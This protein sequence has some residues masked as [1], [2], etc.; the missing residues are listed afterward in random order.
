MKSGRLVKNIF[1]DTIVYGFTRYLAVFA[2]VFLT[3]I[4]TRIL[5]KEDFGTMDIF[6]TWNALFIAILPL[7]LF[8]ALLRFFPDVKDDLTERKKLFGATLTSIFV[9]CMLYVGFIL[10]FKEKFYSIF[11]E[12]ESFNIVFYLSAYIVVNAVLHAYFLQVLQIRF[13]KYKYMTI[14]LINFA[15][16][17]SLGFYL[18]Y[19]L[20]QGIAG[21]FRASAIAF[22]ASNLVGAIFVGRDLHF[23]FDLSKIRMLLSYSI[24]FV[25][26]FFLLQLSQ[27]VDRFLLSEYLNL[28][29]VGIYSVAIRVG[30]ILQIAIS[31]FGTA[32][33]PYAMTIKNE[34]NNKQIYKGMLDIFVMVFV[35][36]IGGMILFRKEI[37]LL[38]APAYMD[39]YNTIFWVLLSNFVMG[40]IYVLSLGIQIVR[41]SKFLSIAAII[42][43]SANFFVSLILVKVVG[44]EGVAIGT[45]VGAMIWIGIQHYFSQKYYK[46][47][48]NY[49]KNLATIALL[50]VPLL[51]SIWLDQN[52]IV[53]LST[54]FIKIAT[55]ILILTFIGSQILLSK[56]FSQTP[57]ADHVLVERTKNLG[58]ALIFYITFIRVRIT[59][60]I[61][62]IFPIQHVIPKKRDVLFLAGYYPENAGYNYRVQKWVDLFEERGLSVKVKSVFKDR[63]EFHDLIEN[64]YRRMLTRSMRIRYFQILSSMRYKKVIIRRS[65][66]LYNDYGN[67]FF[68]KLLLTIHPN[69]IL[70]FDD[71]LDRHGDVPKK[72]L[73]GKLLME[74]EGKFTRSLSVYRRFIVGSNYLK[75]YVIQQNPVRKVDITVIPTCIHYTD[76]EPIVYDDLPKKLVFG[77]IGSDGNQPYLEMVIEGLNALK[78]RMDIELLVI[79]GK[80]YSNEKAKFPIRNESWSLEHEVALLKQAHIGLMPLK[81]TK[82]ELGKC[83][84]KLIQYMGLGMISIASAIGAN[85]DIIESPEMGI[86]VENEN[87]WNHIIE[88]IP[89]RWNELKEKAI[90]G[91]KQIEDKY[92][93]NAN[94][95]EYLR[96][97]NL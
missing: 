90:K 40:L 97:L 29:E 92:S 42:S 48:F 64:K 35:G 51:L 77:W 76:L 15:I 89:D 58:F 84:F 25:T 18:V 44:I 6:N 41:K 93:F 67:L 59:T 12:N 52:L 7:G 30:N 8:N 79:S 96:F 66:L 27:V 26:V 36:I 4:Y 57:M 34:R 22:T 74:V 24:H 85:N 72:G 95:D 78:R 37:I 86:L 39:A 38:F 13:E 20:D 9:A 33:M 11:F 82:L 16:L 80:P 14:S 94:I 81:N 62:K 83:G 45:F 32:W 54:V 3:P 75:E 43:I 68:E 61:F 91:R 65:L 50:A 47:P 2:S 63:S 87:E 1:S 23:N 53:S 56:G 19:A 55:L 60:L 17:A 70:D 31:A 49:L 88:S 10:L 69:A 73:Y 5:T 46:I 71:N 28:K 21:F